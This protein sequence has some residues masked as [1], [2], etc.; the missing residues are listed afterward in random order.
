MARRA[1]RAVHTTARRGGLVP[2]AVAGWIAVMAVWHLPGPFDA[3][4]HTPVL[5]GLEH[6]TFLAASLTLWWAV[7]HAA[8]LGRVGVAV[9]GLFVSGLACTALGALL[10]LAPSPWY[11]AYAHAGVTAALADQQLAGI[12]MWGFANLALVV[13]TAVTVGLWL[14]GLERRSPSRLRPRSL[15]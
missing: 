4:V 15:P 11:P 14:T 10:V 5:H 13:A 7:A 12:V 6:A 2:L 8:A 3:A 1:H 9:L